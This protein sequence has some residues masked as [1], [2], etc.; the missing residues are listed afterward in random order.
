MA[1]KKDTFSSKGSKKLITTNSACTED[2]EAKKA[3]RKCK[4][5]DAII[6]LNEEQE[7]FQDCINDAFLTICQGRAGTGKTFLAL[8]NA[9]KLVYTKKFDKIL[10]VRAYIPTLSVEKDMGA[11]PG[12]AGEKM[13]PCALAVADALGQVL[14]DKELEKLYKEDKIEVSNVSFLRGR[15]LDR[16]III[17]DEAQNCDYNLAHMVISRAGKDSKVIITGSLS[18]I[19]LR[20]RYESF[21]PK[22]INCLAD[23]ENVGV[24]ELTD[25]V[26]NGE[27]NQILTCI[28]EAMQEE[29]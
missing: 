9:L 26:R 5:L 16:T 2:I 10:Y 15:S 1:R 20:A 19:D 25:I 13:A 8:I 17:F 22:L 28:E 3:K 12:S 14:G 6:P 24:I 7:A 18:Q 23:C 29:G 4:S 11:L 21:L 27:L